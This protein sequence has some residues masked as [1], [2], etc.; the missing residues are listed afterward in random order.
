VTARRERSDRRYYNRIRRLRGVGDHELGDHG[1]WHE[2]VPGPFVICLDLPENCTCNRVLR[3][4]YPEVP[5]SITAEFA[6]RMK[7]IVGDAKVDLA[8]PIYGD[9]D[10]FENHEKSDDEC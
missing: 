4:S 10:L 5:K 1:L 2:I 8:E 7:S 3:K 6:A 9:V